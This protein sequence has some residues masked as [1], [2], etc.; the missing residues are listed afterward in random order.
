MLPWRWWRMTENVRQVGRGAGGER[1]SVPRSFRPV[2]EMLEDRLVPS[3]LFVTPTGSGDGSSWAS[4]A[5]LQS[6][7]SSAG[8]GDQ[9]WV[10]EG[11]YK[12]TS[13]TSRDIYFKLKDGVAVY[14]GFVGTETLLSQRNFVTHVTTLS[15]DIGTAN[16]QTDNSYH[17]VDTNGVSSTGILDGFTITAGY[18]NGVTTIERKGGG[19]VT[20]SGSATLNNLIVT[21]N[22]SQDAGGGMYSQTASPTLTNVTFS[23]NTTGTAGGGMDVNVG[24]ADFDECRLRQ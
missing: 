11:T 24:F 18:A 23:G 13:G 9:V 2:L 1:V 17:V 15:G 12:P 21:G 20:T 6:A 19:L 8:S 5:S 14:G 22:S 10:K 4:A 16:D 3:T 7:L